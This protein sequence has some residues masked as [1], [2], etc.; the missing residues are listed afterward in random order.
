M[1]VAK[2]VVEGKYW[3]IKDGD[4]K[5]GEVEKQGK[6]FEVKMG[7]DIT[8]HGSIANIADRYNVKFETTAR[9][10]NQ[11]TESLMGYPTD[12]RPQNPM[13]SV[14]YKLPLFAKS[15]NSKSLFAAGWYRVTRDG[16]A[17]WEFC[18][19]LIILQRY[20]FEG[21]YKEKQ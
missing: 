15:R 18:P 7:D 6:S 10:Q 1:I 17:R 5:V 12:C 3:I 4:L 13:Y 2:P 20:P 8:V 21:P 11:A 19:K 9:K 14:Q 16:E